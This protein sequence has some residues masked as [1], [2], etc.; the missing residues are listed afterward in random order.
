MNQKD[1]VILAVKEQG[2]VRGSRV[3]L[4]DRATAIYK[5]HRWTQYERTARRLF[6]QGKKED[7]ALYMRWA[8]ES[9]PVTPTYAALVRSQWLKAKGYSY[10]GRTHL[11]VPG[12]DMREPN[13]PALAV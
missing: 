8:M 12:R 1:A 4:A 3:A 7:A 11:D 5:E 13:H 9:D 10:D 6:I 2:N